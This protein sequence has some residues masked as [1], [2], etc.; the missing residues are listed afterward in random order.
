MWNSNLIVN[1]YRFLF[2]YSILIIS[3]LSFSCPAK[4]APYLELGDSGIEVIELQKSLSNQGFYRSP[5]DGYY[6]KETQQAVIRFQKANSLSVDGIAGEQTQ[7]MLQSRLSLAPQSTATQVFSQ[8]G[9]GSVEGILTGVTTSE[10]L[11]FFALSVGI[12]SVIV[13]SDSSKQS[14]QPGKQAGQARYQPLKVKLDLYFKNKYLLTLGYFDA[15]STVKLGINDPD[16]LPIIKTSS[17]KGIISMKNDLPKGRYICEIT[18]IV[19]GIEI[20][21]EKYFEV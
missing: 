11:S 18:G 1:K 17:N 2:F 3:E 8:A 12:T 6:G 21:N 5:A 19:D 15:G 14:G 20:T 13:Y 4:S 16:G 7:S 9:V 10:I